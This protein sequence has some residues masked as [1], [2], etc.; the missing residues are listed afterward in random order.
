[1][2]PHVGKEESRDCTVMQVG[3]SECC[4]GASFRVPFTCPLPA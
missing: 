3:C 2:W 4:V 1:M